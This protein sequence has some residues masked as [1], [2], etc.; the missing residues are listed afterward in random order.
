[1]T[2]EL[3][4]KIRYIMDR[5]IGLMSEY[6]IKKQC[7]D[8]DID[9]DNIGPDDARKLAVVFESVIGIFGGTEKAMRVKMEIRRLAQGDPGLAQEDLVLT[10]GANGS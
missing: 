1:M 4:T 2:S 5:E 8:L 9:P 10:P 6:I 7:K 3:S